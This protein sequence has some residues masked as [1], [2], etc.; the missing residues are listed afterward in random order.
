MTTVQRAEKVASSLVKDVLAA[1]A[2]ERER[3]EGF[4]KEQ[5]AREEMWEKRAEKREQTYMDSMTSMM[6][7]MSQFVDAM[8][9]FLGPC[10][11]KAE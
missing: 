10:Y 3:H 7:V 4:E 5:S 9:Y 8:M 1:Q 6:S 2:K 11:R